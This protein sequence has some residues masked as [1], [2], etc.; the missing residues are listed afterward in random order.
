[1]TTFQIKN[2]Q[3]FWELLLQNPSGVWKSGQRCI[4]E[5][6]SNLKVAPGTPDQPNPPRAPQNTQN[7]QNTQ[8]SLHQYHVRQPPKEDPLVHPISYPSPQ[9]LKMHPKK[10][11]QAPEEDPSAP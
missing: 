1:M 4:N 6:T 7:T 10:T 2:P 5:L 9:D 8:N 11:P 3:G